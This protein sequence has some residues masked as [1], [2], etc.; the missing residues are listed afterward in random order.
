MVATVLTGKLELIIFQEVVHEDDEFAHAGGQGDQ[1][2]FT[3]S[4]QAQ[5]EG[6]KNAVMADGAQGGHVEGATD[7]MSAAADVTALGLVPAITVVGSQAGQRGGGLGIEM[8]QLGHFRQDSGGHDRTDPRDGIQSFGFVRQPGIGGND[9]GN[10]QITLVDLFIEQLLELAVLTHAERIGVMLGAVALDGAGVD[11][12][13][14]ALGE[15]GQA[16][17]LGRNRRGRCWL[18]G[19]RIGCEDGRIDG[20]GFSPLALGAGEV[21]DPPGFE[22][23]DGDVGCLEGAHGGLFIAAGGFTDHVHA[24]VR[25]QEFEELG[26]A[27]WVIGQAVKTACQ[28]KLQRELGNVQADIEDGKVVLTHTCK[29]TSPGDRWSPCSSNGSSLGQWA[30]AKHAEERI[31]PERMQGENV[32]ARAAALRPAGRRAAPAWLAFASQPSKTIAKIQGER[33]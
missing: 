14:A 30:R 23:A 4:P 33:I 28:M 2:F 6:F 24:L 13:A 18:E 22:D 32:S 11:E 27:L 1:G 29:D 15:A 12:L 9:L 17:L 8:S 16:L 26:V 7:G 31:T 5:I 10:G 25:A 20:I 19:L 21:T 3:G